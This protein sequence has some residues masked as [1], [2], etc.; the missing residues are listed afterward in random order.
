MKIKFLFTVLLAFVISLNNLYSQSEQGRSKV[1]VSPYTLQIFTVTATGGQ[2]TEITSNSAIQPNT[3]YYVRI[4]TSSSGVA[5]LLARSADG[6]E[7]GLWNNGFVPYNDP[8]S[9]QGDG[10]TLVFRIRTFTGF[11]FFTPL[12]VRVLECSSNCANPGG[13]G[14]INPKAILFPQP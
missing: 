10:S 12:Y 8:T 6:F 7:T 11:D 14:W 3:V 5:S 9:A 4:T 1:V 2:G 13:P